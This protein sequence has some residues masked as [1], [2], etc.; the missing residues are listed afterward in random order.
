MG[1]N[2]QKLKENPGKNDV[3]NSVRPCFSN[4]ISPS[5]FIQ[6]YQLSSLLI[7]HSNPYFVRFILNVPG[8]AFEIFPL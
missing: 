6:D 4:T 1:G 5:D 3:E 2:H 7:S 8:I